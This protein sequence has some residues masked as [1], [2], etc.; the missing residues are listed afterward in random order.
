M[1]LGVI[2]LCHNDTDTYIYNIEDFSSITDDSY[3]NT[4]GKLSK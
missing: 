3:V 2:D 4:R 1:N